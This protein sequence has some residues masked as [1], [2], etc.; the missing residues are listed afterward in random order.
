M[1]Q[2][3]HLSFQ[4]ESCF[5]NSNHDSVGTW[6]GCVWVKRV[7]NIYSIQVIRPAEA[8]RD[9]PLALSSWMV[10]GVSAVYK[11][12]Q[13]RPTWA[14]ACVKIIVQGMFMGVLVSKTNISLHSLFSV[15]LDYILFTRTQKYW[16]VRNWESVSAKAKLIHTITQSVTV[17]RS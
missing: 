4:N 14:N 5:K 3:M 2:C 13:N 7:S 1:I 9:L 6:K 8:N 15:L 10:I 11:M 17:S 16:R 12:Q